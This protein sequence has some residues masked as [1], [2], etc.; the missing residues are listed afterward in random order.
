MSGAEA[1]KAQFKNGFIMPAF[2]LEEPSFRQ[3]ETGSDGQLMVL[4]EY[5]LYPS[6]QAEVICTAKQ[7][8]TFCY[9][10]ENGASGCTI[11]TFPM[12]IPSW[13]AM[14]SFLFR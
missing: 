4:G 12:S 2:E 11:C 7:R 5:T 8:A 6:E 3:I 9:R 10:Q 1:I 14:K 13:W